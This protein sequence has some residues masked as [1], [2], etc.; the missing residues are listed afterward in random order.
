MSRL[1][2][3]ALA[4]ARTCAVV[5]SLILGLL[6]SDASH[7]DLVPKVPGQ[8]WFTR[9]TTYFTIH[10]DALNVDS[11]DELASM[12][13]AIYLDVTA[14]F[15]FPLKHK[16]H[17]VVIDSNDTTNGAALSNLD[18]VL[19]QPTA[20]YLDSF[21][22]RGRS[23]WLKNVFTHEFTHIVTLKAATALGE[24]VFVVDPM[25]FRKKSAVEGIAVFPLMGKI[26]PYW[27]SEGI[28]QHSA[29]L[30]GNDSYDTHR[31]MFLRTAALEDNMLTLQDMSVQ[32]ALKG[33]FKPELA[34]NQGFSL[35]RYLTEH[36]GIISHEEIAKWAAEEWNLIFDSNFKERRLPSLADVYASWKTE[37]EARELAVANAILPR[38]VKGR[39][40]DATS[41]PAPSAKN[42]ASIP[43]KTP[44]ER[45]ALSKKGLYHIRPQVSPDGKYMAYIKDGTLLILPTTRILV[46]EGQYFTATFTTDDNLRVNSFDWAKDSRTIALTGV[47]RDSPGSLTGAGFNDLGLLD[48]LPFAEKLDERFTA[49]EQAKKDAGAQALPLDDPKLW[50]IAKEALGKPI[51]EIMP[52]KASGLILSSYLGT[53][54]TVVA[55]L[56]NGARAHDVSFSPDNT[57]LIYVRNVGGTQKILGS[58]N[59]HGYLS[60]SIAYAAAKWIQEHN[61]KGPKQLKTG[62][63]VANALYLIDKVNRTVPLER[64]DP[65]FPDLG[66]RYSYP[67]GRISGDVGLSNLYLALLNG[68]GKRLGSED[69][70]R[71]FDTILALRDYKPE[72]PLVDANTEFFLAEYPGIQC[73]TPRFSPDG[74]KIAFS[75]YYEGKQNLYLYD[76]AA[77]QLVQLTDDEFENRDPV[78]T[79]EGRSLLYVSDRGGIFNLHEYDIAQRSSTQ[80]SNVLS[81]VFQPSYRDGVVHFSYFTSFGFRVHALKREDFLVDEERPLGEPKQIAPPAVT[82]ETLAFRADAAAL[83]SP[84]SAT[85]IPLQ[86]VPELRAFQKQYGAGVSLLAMDYLDTHTISLRA[87]LDRDQI[88]SAL[89]QHKHFLGMFNAEVHYIKTNFGIGRLFD[90]TATTQLQL[91][92]VPGF[93][94]KRYQVSGSIGNTFTILGNQLSLTYNYRD[95]NA[96]TSAILYGGPDLEDQH[97]PN[98]IDQNGSFGDVGKFGVLTN[99]TMDFKWKIDGVSRRNDGDI[100][101]RGSKLTTGYSLTF[102]NV[103]ERFSNLG[104]FGAFETADPRADYHFHALD[105]AYDK[106]IGMNELFADAKLLA[107]NTIGYS[108][109]MTALDRDVRAYDELYLGGKQVF[110]TFRDINNSLTFPGYEAFSLSGE[111]RFLAN[112]RYRFPIFRDLGKQ[113]G[114][115]YVDDCFVEVFADAGNAWDYGE[116]AFTYKKPKATTLAKSPAILFD[117]GANLKLKT[118]MFYNWPFFSFFTAAHGFQDADLTRARNPSANVYPVHFYVGIGAG[119]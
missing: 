45:E 68:D 70:L 85:F 118:Y 90:E 12:C 5:S 30:A 111:A 15:H 80:R 87:Y 10:Y 55:R 31:Q 63:N 35:S 34:Y 116:T 23:N 56:T 95:I 47:F 40:W 36:F 105:F 96:E 75:G 98:K 11:A 2:N 108:V 69:S 113:Y 25:I 57:Q 78:F 14:R 61:G 6:H 21:N 72:K 100:N 33:A 51:A 62:P 39:A 26:T 53:R 115:M 117:T 107:N 24:R 67:F 3:T 13:D 89:Y 4:L 114:F 64:L 46:G 112:V 20:L 52:T 16:I 103:D 77:K 82:Q 92:E 71:A 50:A 109:A 54:P 119:L 38:E 84:Y 91:K 18:W 94:A 81:A 19:I 42:W 8:D 88:F 93:F 29:E 49:Y 32:E 110:R 37:T 73:H 60:K 101:P 79:E 22:L 1:T 74:K 59:L 17:V 41:D 83:A 58:F 43:R 97:W 66:M 7:A 102:T 44:E 104:V 106:D 76:I 48:F 28:A 86:I 27:W 65:L 99:H 9:E